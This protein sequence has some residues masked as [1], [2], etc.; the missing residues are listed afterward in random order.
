VPQH[1]LVT[2]NSLSGFLQE[3][4]YLKAY[5]VWGAAF[6]NI[7]LD[8]NKPVSPPRLMKEGSM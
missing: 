4:A 7:S 2:W 5:D 3:G 8:I 1:L 6:H